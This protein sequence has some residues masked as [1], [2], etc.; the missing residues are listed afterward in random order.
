VEQYFLKPCFGIVTAL[1]S[2]NA[3]LKH[4]LAVVLKST[5][6][7]VYKQNNHDAVDVANRLG[8]GIDHALAIL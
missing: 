3:L 7:Q 4:Y 5:I 1:T 2:K 8:Y 6:G